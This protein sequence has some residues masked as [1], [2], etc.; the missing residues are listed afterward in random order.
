MRYLFEAGQLNLSDE[1][2]FVENVLKL[3]PEL[4]LLIWS[5][6]VDD[7][8][9]ELAEK[10]FYSES[11][12]VDIQKLLKLS[13]LK[14]LTPLLYSKM[15][16]LDPKKINKRFTKAFKDIY[17]STISDNMKLSNNIWRAVNLLRNNGL[18]P[19]PYK[20]PTLGI[21][22][23][24]D[25]A[26]RSSADIDIMIHNFEFEQA[27]NI[28]VNNGYSI[29]V[30]SKKKIIKYTYK[31]WRDINLEKGEY[32]FD[33]HQQIE[34]GPEFFRPDDDAFKS[35]IKVKLNKK[36]IKTFSPEE[37]LVIMAI[38]C[39][40]DGYGSFKHYRDITGI[41]IKNP[42]LNWEKVF[43]SAG[44][45]KSLKIV[46]I[47]LK[48]SKLFCGLKLPEDISEAIETKSLN[49]F[50]DNLVGRLFFKN[51][52][53]DILT[54]ILTIP[55]SLDTVFSKIRF[56]FWFFLHPS[57]QMHPPIFRLPGKL[58]F[59]IPFISPL[60]LFCDYTSRLLKIKLNTENKK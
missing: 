57:P 14:G 25:I 42:D 15:K 49:R 6:R 39:A 13:H 34:K 31:T 38:N 28:F 45:K 19:I 24:G 33:I 48:F 47:S 56:Y 2:R 54:N 46:K 50:F 23:Y 7:L 35:C 36:E 16:A 60:Y 3:S 52:E 58:F 53:L 44:K 18:D 51:F 1:K 40:S 4:Q 27:I 12:V 22:A 37:T 11:P 59:L 17:F 20:G 43:F 10:Y 32:H 5:V 9:V 41:I 29:P 8:F 21:I 26:L 30:S 55:K